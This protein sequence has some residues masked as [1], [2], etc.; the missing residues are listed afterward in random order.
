LLVLGWTAAVQAGIHVVGPGNYREVLA[1]LEPGDTLALE[2]GDYRDGLPV[3]G[4]VGTQEQP[5]H[6]AGPQSGKPA[7]IH[8]RR[9]SNVVSIVDSRWVTLRNLVI[10][11][12]GRNADGIKAEG[13]AEFAH[14]ITLSD[15]V[16]RNLRR[17]QQV[18]GISTK[19]P[20]RG[21][22]VRNNEIHGAGTGMYFGDSDGTAPFVDALIEHNLITGSIGY[23]LQIKHQGARPPIDGLPRD[24][25]VSVIR[26]NVFAKDETS[27]TDNRARP[28][29]LLGHFPPR[30]PGSNDRYA[31]YG[32]L[33]YN[34]PTERLFQGEGSIALYSN[35]FVNPAGDAIAIMPHNGHPRRIDIFHNTIVA[36]GTGIWF[37][38]SE[39][40]ERAL[41]LGNAVFAG[42]PFSGDGAGAEGNVHAGFDKAGAYLRAPHA[43]PGEFDLVP[44][45]DRLLGRVALPPEVLWDLHDVGRDFDGVER[46]G[47]RLGAYEGVEGQPRWMP[48]LAIKRVLSVN[49]SAGE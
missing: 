48:E 47:E 2:A 8:P 20:A 19:C 12:D 25:S 32:N 26:H 35:L 14:Y 13:H 39:R 21:W 9:G 3:H 30:G 24:R 31:V 45:D 36:R 34:N 5:I 6:I 42:K 1:R 43:G 17:H 7:V 27:S 11:G 10:D 18:V 40:T 49:G 38:R 15:L 16:I 29:V 28:S 46:S 4:L 44:R 41:V 23:A 33:F 22:I 37:K